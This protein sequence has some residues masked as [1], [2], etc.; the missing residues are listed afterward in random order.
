MELRL[1]AEERDAIYEHVIA[2]LSGIGDLWIAVER[3]EPGQV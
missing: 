2:H 3:N 1:T